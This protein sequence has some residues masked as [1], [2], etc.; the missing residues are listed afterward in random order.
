MCNQVI[1]PSLVLS[2]KISPNGTFNCIADLPSSMLAN[3]SNSTLCFDNAT[4]SS[5]WFS[6]SAT[7]PILLRTIEFRSPYKSDINQTLPVIPSSVR[8][9]STLTS[10]DNPVWYR[11]R[12]DRD[13]GIPWTSLPV[14]T[15]G[16]ASVPDGFEFTDMQI[17]PMASTDS[18]AM[19]FE[20]FFY[21][22]RS[23]ETEV[24]R[25]EFNSTKSAIETTFSAMQFFEQAVSQILSEHTNISDS[26]YIVHAG[27]T[28]NSIVK[29]YV[30]LLPDSA[31][32][33]ESVSSLMKSMFGN[34]S[35]I[36]ALQALQGYIEDTDASLCHNKFCESG[37][38]CVNGR[39]YNQ[40]GDSMLPN[41]VPPPT[42][43]R[44]ST[45]MRFY[46]ESDT[47]TSDSTTSMNYI[48][49]IAI[50]GVL[51]LG[52]VGVL[53]NHVINSK[54]ARMKAE[55]GSTDETTSLIS[56]TRSPT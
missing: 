1:D 50:G 15:E 27:E 32:G 20:P 18:T 12:E 52:L 7:T 4:S 30:R 33:A 29:V 13:L 56:D 43:L 35:L 14:T 23:N 11:T 10:A 5:N 28:L 6:I 45:N 8:L 51:L 26:R 25:L 22:C 37:W 34:K 42:Q 24:V 9:Q 16:V 2:M 47:S 40:E 49:P 41:L 36:K 19:D 44:I 3:S 53:V 39:C 46:S 55:R 31:P 48:V 17:W 54:R 21:G 38:L